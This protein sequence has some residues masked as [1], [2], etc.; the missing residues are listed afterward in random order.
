MFVFHPA[1]DA[2]VGAWQV[3]AVP[4]PLLS[5]VQSAIMLIAL[6]TVPVAQLLTGVLVQAVGPG[7]T[8]FLLAA[9]LLLLVLAVALLSSSLRRRPEE[10]AP[11]P[12]AC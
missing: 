9:A 1:W 5:R 7:P 3:R 11:A 10:P 4:K 6:G 12:F 8:I 2:S